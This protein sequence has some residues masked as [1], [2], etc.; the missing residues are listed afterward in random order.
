MRDMSK[1]AKGPHQ[2]PPVSNGV[3]SLQRL[4]AKLEAGE[5][6][7]TVFR[8]GGRYVATSNEFALTDQTLTVSL[9]T[10]IKH[11]NSGDLVVLE[12]ERANFTF[13]RHK[14]TATLTAWGHGEVVVKSNAF[15]KTPSSTFT[16]DIAKMWSH[17]LAAV[18]THLTAVGLQ[19]VETPTLV[20]NPGMEPEL[21]PF[22]AALKN[23]R[24]QV[25]L[26]LA[27]SPELHLKQ[28]LAMGFSDIFEIKTVF[29]NEE[30]TE[31]HEPEFHMLEW[32]RAFANLDAIEADLIGLVAA[33]AGETEPVKK[34]SVA[35]LFE[36]HTDFVL[37]PQTTRDELYT[38]A[39]KFSLAPSETM[40]F[41]D[42]FHL[43]WLSNVE[44]KMPQGPVLL[45]HY[46]PS[47]A[48][49][50]RIGSHGWAERFE[51]YWKGVEI[52]NAFHEL[53]DPV[54]QR[55][56]FESDQIKRV[57]YGRTPLKIDENFMTSLEYGMPPSGGI[58]LGLD[59]LFMVA[60]G[61]EALRSTRA[62]SVKHEFSDNKKLD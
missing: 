32:Y 60:N 38:L 53:N 41:N 34:F 37:K 54:E 12:A 23:G 36:L 44:P 57:E 4:R 51:L 24:V 9:S 62:F 1:A 29:R 7:P 16:L 17:F 31:F 21:E 42:L 18:R 46:P 30:L 2:Y 33:V 43:I 27:T 14:K 6:L 48:A 5:T 45:G 59:R 10:A 11:A 52:A 56:R 47:Q 40:G 19:E 15:T 49:L 58:A 3:F 50:S 55:R 8:L 26:F 25:P 39:Q 22:H 20:I 61:F 13:D 28:L 35:E